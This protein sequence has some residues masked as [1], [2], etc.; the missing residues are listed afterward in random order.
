MP[1][2]GLRKAPHAHDYTDTDPKTME[3]WLDLIRKKTPGERLAMAFQLSEF[4]LQ[5]N[6][7]GVRMR[8]PE[9]DDREVFL[10]GAALRL[11][12]DQMIAAYGWDPEADGQPR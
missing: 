3:V 6:Y 10:R 8:H 1:V 2:P 4:A 12:R 7:A 11:S 9:A 5:M